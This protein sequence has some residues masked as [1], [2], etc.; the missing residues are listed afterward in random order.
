[1]PF[2]TIAMAAMMAAPAAGS[3]PPPSQISA[4]TACRAIADPQRRLACYDNASQQ[5][6]RALAS[7][8]LSVFSR[9]DLRQTRRSLFGFTLPKLP[10]LGGDGEVEKQITA[11]LASVRSSGYGKWQFRLEDGA[12]WE[13]T[14]PTIDGM[15]PARGESVTIKTGVLGNYFIIFEGMGAVRG[16]RVS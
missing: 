13:T 6:E 3:A 7:K 2:L 12:L 10:F 16:R 4:F 11:K 1:M 5:L 9:N 15:V 14:E 8:E